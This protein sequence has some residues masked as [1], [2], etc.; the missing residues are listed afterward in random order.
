M[1]DEPLTEV[2][3]DCQ[4]EWDR[5][6]GVL[7]VHDKVTGHTVLRI[8]GMPKLPTTWYGSLLD[9]GSIDVTMPTRVSYIVGQ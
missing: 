7:Y 9:G 6:R 2:I 4:L 5:E 3:K 1:F 8:C